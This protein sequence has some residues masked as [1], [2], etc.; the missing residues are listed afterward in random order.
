M[1]NCFKLLVLMACL[2][3][4][5]QP[6]TAQET[7]DTPVRYNV[8]DYFFVQPGNHADYQAVEKVWKKIHQA[9]IKAGKYLFWE[10]TEIT[11]GGNTEYNYATRIVVEGEEQ[12]AALLSGKSF[13]DN[14]T[15]MLSAEDK[16]ILNHTGDTRTWIKRE[17]Y[18]VSSI[19]P[20]ADW[21]EVNVAVHNYFG[22]PKG[23]NHSKH[24]EVEKDIWEPIHA[25]RIKEGKLL[26]WVLADKVLP[27]GAAEPFHDVTV[28]L[29]KDLESCLKSSSPMPYFA[30]VHPGKDVAQ[31][32][33][34]TDAAATLL[35][36][37]V[38]LILDN[39]DR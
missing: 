23:S 36:S 20:A 25:A 37:E 16:A 13:Q 15:S 3:L 1:K 18:T 11:I 22:Y 38:R 26:A 28:D 6:L 29:Y 27:W 4:T 2:V 8:H 21:K 35:R 34:Q 17:V 19:L 7:T 33:E 39:T 24:V 31:L 5:M 9:N 10:L 30:K 12:L 32:M 14:P